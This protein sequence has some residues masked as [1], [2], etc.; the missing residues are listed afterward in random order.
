[1]TDTC[2]A[3]KTKL[4]SLNI[5][6]Q[7]IETL[8]HWCIFHRKNARALALVWSEELARAPAKQK[9]AYLYLASDIVQNARKKGTDWAD[10]MVDLA[11][12]ACRDVATSGD[13]K[14]AERVRKVLRIWDERKVFGSAPVTTWLD[15]ADGAG[16]TTAGAKPSARAPAEPSVAVKKN[17]R[18]L[19]EVPALSG[20]N[21]ALAKL[22]VKMETAEREFNEATERFAADVK[23]DLLDEKALDETSDPPALLRALQSAE[24][25]IAAK[26]NAIETTSETLDGLEK[27]LRSALERVDALRQK[28]DQ[29]VMSELT[30][31]AVKCATLRMKAS[32]KAAA[33]VAMQAASGAS[34]PP[35]AAEREDDANDEDAYL[36]EP[37]DFDAEDDDQYDPTDAPEEFD[38]GG[39]RQR[40]D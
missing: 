37:V 22:L 3:F 6:V 35:P 21:A 13:D 18:D 15:G 12:T 34:A 23:E 7:S 28:Q 9:L 27:K 24:S 33:F 40:T 8:S 36:P 25:A 11:P 4:A 31:M 10:A 17:K 20:E 1:M 2:R 39:K 16:T 5:S 30:Q 38:F 14:T 32:K 26:R 19:T 29:S